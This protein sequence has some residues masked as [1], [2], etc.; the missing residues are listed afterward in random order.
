MGVE[1]ATFAAASLTIGAQ[2]GGS[3]AVIISGAGS[4]ITLSG[5]LNVGGALGTGGLTMGP[6]A[7]V[8]AAVV[9]LQGQVVMQG[10][11]LDPTVQ[12]INKNQ[13]IGG[14]GTIVAGTLIDEGVIEAG[15]DT[16]S[17]N[18]LLVEGTVL[19]GGTLT[20]NGTPVASKPAGVPRV[21]AGGTLELAGAVLNAARTTVTDD[22]TP[23]G[24]YTV[25]DSVVDVTTARQS[26]CSRNSPRGSHRKPRWRGKRA[27][28]R[29]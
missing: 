13:A 14:F 21:N 1:R 2:G 18:L 16:A 27:G 23:A 15:T 22:T 10:G 26:G 9:N 19:G 28:R 24:T 20:V 29:S 12:V 4:N 25:N 7:A 5:A 17:P 11:L 8:H 3:G 6:G